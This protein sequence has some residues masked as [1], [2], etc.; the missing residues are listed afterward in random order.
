[1]SEGQAQVLI[2]DTSALDTSSATANIAENQARL[3]AKANVDGIDIR[4]FSVTC[5]HIYAADGR[6]NGLLES[7]SMYVGAGGVVVSSEG[8]GSTPDTGLIISDSSIRLRYGGVDTVILDGATGLITALK[9]LLQSASSGARF[10]IDTTGVHVYDANSVERT[11][12]SQAGLNIVA[13]SPTGGQVAAEQKAT[14]TADGS[15][16][17]GGIFLSRNTYTL[18]RV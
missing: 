3:E 2:T 1:M 18:T 16:V 17:E 8:G 14:F 12:L 5:D 10:E 9:F 7:G 11:R 15:D 13:T 4:P 6:F